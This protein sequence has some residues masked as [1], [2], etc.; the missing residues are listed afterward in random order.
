MSCNSYLLL[1]LKAISLSLLLVLPLTAEAYRGESAVIQDSI[2]DGVPSDGLPGYFDAHV[3]GR[4]RA[5]LEIP[6]MTLDYG[7]TENFT[8]GVN[9]LPGFILLAGQPAFMGKLR[10]RFFST[11]KLASTISVYGGGFLVTPERSEILSSS[12]TYGSITSNTT[13]YFDRYTSINFHLT[14]ARLTTAVEKSARIKEEV[15]LFGFIPG[16]QVQKYF[17]DSFGLEGL[18]LIPLVTQATGDTVGASFDL[19]L[20][21]L[22]GRTRYF[23]FRLMGNLKTGDEAVLSFGAGGITSF[24][25]SKLFPMITFTFGV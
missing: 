19:N 8:V 4:G 16:I 6:T 20:M 18:F 21:Y 13:Y 15:S 9:A 7:V 22:N 10:Y 1:R 11:D 12:L 5:V 24:K 23:P 25:E 17:S 2:I 3:A 14:A